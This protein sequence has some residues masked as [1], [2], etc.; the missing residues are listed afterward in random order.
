MHDFRIN[1]LAENTDGEYALAILEDPDVERKE[2]QF[3]I[4][5]FYEDQH[6]MKKC[7][8]HKNMLFS[9]TLDIIYTHTDLEIRKYA[10][11]I[12]LTKF[13]PLEDITNEMLDN[14]DQVLEYEMRAFLDRF[15]HFL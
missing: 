2:L 3:I 10:K 13:I 8:R 6:I 14:F 9:D 11:V 4:E 5:T 7:I 12:I 15:Q 1:I